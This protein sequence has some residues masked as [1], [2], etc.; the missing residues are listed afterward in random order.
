MHR[1]RTT[2]H[3]IFA[4]VLSLALAAPLLAEAGLLD[5][6]RNLVKG[7][8]PRGAAATARPPARYSFEPPVAYDAGPLTVE[9]DGRW[10][11]GGSRLT[12]HAKSNILMDDRQLA[13]GDLRL[14]QEARVMGH[15]LKDGTLQVRLLTLVPPRLLPAVGTMD[16]AQP[17]V[18]KLP[19]GAPR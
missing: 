16:P 8:S 11:V 5:F 15:R 1:P 18:G 12:L 3:R 14:G 7:K 17:V 4:A 9:P 6:A 13:A 19:P 10:R 2:H